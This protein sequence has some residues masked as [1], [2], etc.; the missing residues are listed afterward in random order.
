[1]GEIHSNAE[2]HSITSVTLPSFQEHPRVLKKIFKFKNIKEH[3]GCV[4]TLL[5]THAAITLTHPDDSA[6]L[7]TDTLVRFVSGGSAP[8]SVV[9]ERLTFAT[10]GS[11]G[12]MLTAADNL[13]LKTLASTPNTLA[14]VPITLT[15]TT[16][17]S[18]TCLPG[19][20]SE[21][22]R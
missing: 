13:L 4:Q 8:W 2:E 6:W 14:R 5:M 18:T 16:T 19:Q 10:L 7:L 15:P 17:E 22:T 21:H 3:L 1:M 11:L 9:V 12:V 20:Y